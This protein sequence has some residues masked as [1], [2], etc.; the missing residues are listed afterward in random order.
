M[1]LKT[2]TFLR[3][4]MPVG[5]NIKYAKAHKKLNAGKEEKRCKNKNL[6]SVSTA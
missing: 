5:N 1:Q 3:Y 6:S 4:A 2:S